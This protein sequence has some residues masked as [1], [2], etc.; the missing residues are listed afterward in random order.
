[1]RGLSQGHFDITRVLS[2]GRGRKVA[3][4]RPSARGV[5]FATGLRRRLATS[6][7]RLSRR[8]RRRYHRRRRRRHAAPVS[9]RCQAQRAGRGVVLQ[10]VWELRRPRGG[11]H[12][13]CAGHP[14]RHELRLS[15]RR[16][17]PAGRAR[18]RTTKLL[19]QPTYPPEAQVDLIV[20][21]FLFGLFVAVSTGLTLLNGAVTVLP[22][23]SFDA[24]IFSLLLCYMPTPAQRYRCCQKARQLLRPGGLLL[25]ITPDSNHA[26]KVPSSIS[27]PRG[28]VSCAKLL[29]NKHRVLCFVGRT[30]N[31][32][33][34]TGH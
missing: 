6:H 18:S 2:A 30:Q 22:G 1:M 13:H 17:G 4:Q 12:R 29:K 25:V 33:V 26:A 5:W 14:G 11:A 8:Y 27:R 10:S 31:A 32:A 24:C 9:G 19:E 20:Q 21:S 16:G 34:A 7:R 23:A 15:Q 28:Q 3:C